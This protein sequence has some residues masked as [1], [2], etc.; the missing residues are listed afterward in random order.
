MPEGLDA[1]SLAPVIR[2]RKA[3]V[4][5]V[6]FTTYRN[7]QKPIRDDRWKLIRYPLID[8]TQ[9]FDLQAD[10][11]E[12]HDLAN[13]PEH[14]GKIREL[15]GRMKDAQRAFGDTDPLHVANPAA[16]AWG[17]AVDPKGRDPAGPRAP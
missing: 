2:G 13:E 4:R 10:P 3:T 16:A 14:A 8:K 6:L 7:C 15:M 5:D 11:H 12:M 1:T 17:P 9:L